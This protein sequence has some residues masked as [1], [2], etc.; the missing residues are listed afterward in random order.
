MGFF[1]VL[2][3]GFVYVT[4]TWFRGAH[5]TGIDTF[6]TFRALP[7]WRWFSPLQEVS[8]GSDFIQ[9]MQ[10]KERYIFVVMP[11]VTNASL[12]W[13]FGLHARW[14]WIGVRICYLMP[15]ILFYFPVVRELLLWSGACASTTPGRNDVQRVVD[16]TELGRNVAYSPNGMQDALSTKPKSPPMLLFQQAVARK[17]HVVPVLTQ[18][19]R[20][21]GR[22]LFLR[23]GC[24]ALR[25]LQEWFLGKIGY[26][27]PHI[28]LPRYGRKI[29][30]AVGPPVSPYVHISAEAMQAKFLETIKQISNVMMTTEGNGNNNDDM[31]EYIVDMKE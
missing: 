31:V 25:A 24:G 1:W 17:Y 2:M 5:M 7:V 13:F 21:D 18:G 20:D 11:N 8:G 12:I 6:E 16:M 14:S 10:S 3:T 15:Q 28:Y 29:E 4:L 30:I 23:D 26:P 19:E 27:F 22:Y 9:D